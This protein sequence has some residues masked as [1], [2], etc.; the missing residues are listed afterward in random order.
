MSR[1]LQLPPWLPTH[2]Q[3]RSADEAAR[4]RQLQ[5]APYVLV[6]IAGNAG[7]DAL[8]CRRCRRLH[9]HLTLMCEIQPFYGLTEGLYAYSKALGISGQERW[10]T[11][12]QKIR[13]AQLSKFLGPADDLPDMAT[14][15]P[16]TVREMGLADGD[17]DLRAVA[18]GVLEPI[19][20]ATAQRLLD[21][22]NAR[23][24]KPPLVVHG[25]VTNGR[26]GVQI[27]PRQRLL[28]GRP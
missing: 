17:A 25:L 27:A 10:L 15:H 14:S 22:I 18:I 24:I 9:T 23:G 7:Y 13:L 1:N 26:M 20:Q 2:E 16:R 8:R 19:S 5:E 21:A 12:D 28:A 3:R 4:L 6:R 11:P